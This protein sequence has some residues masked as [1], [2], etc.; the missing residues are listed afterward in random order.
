MLRIGVFDTETTG[1]PFHSQALLENQPKIIEF[2][3]IITDGDSVLA[4]EEFICNPD[5][6]LEAIITK[7]TGL[8][9]E[10]LEDAPPWSDFVPRVRDYFAG[11]DVIITHNL[12]FDKSMV[13]YDMRRI[14]KGLPDVSW[15]HQLEIC[16]VE[17]TYHQF[18]RRM[19]LTELYN[20]LVGEYV[21]KH[22][23]LDDVLIHHEV[24]K[25]LG[26]YEA[27]NGGN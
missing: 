2:A 9:D 20:L 6:P 1:L 4:T 7:I 21:Q 10:D 23:A 3:G 26:L 15:E 12:S 18:G 22:R 13:L 16:T 27:L 19:K 14:G 8:K 17:Q 5:Q 11:C 24:C 25:R